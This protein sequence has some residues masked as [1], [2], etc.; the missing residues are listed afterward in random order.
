M[1]FS[2]F[3]GLFFLL[4][5]FF[6]LSSFLALTQGYTS[7]QR[8][9]L[10]LEVALGTMA[11]GITLFLLGNHIFALFGINL[12]SFRMGTG[13]LLMLSAINLVQGGS[14]A[15]LKGIDREAISI[16]PL[17]IPITVGPATVG[18]LL[19]L[20]SEQTAPAEAALT[21]GAFALAACAVGTLL[22]ISSWIERVLG[23]SG[24]TI[25]SKITGLILSALAAQMFMQGFT[26]F[27]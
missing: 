26:Q 14:T 16:V 20:S 17:A 1:F 10:A 7:A 4:T 21:L 9:R 3:I 25:L 27:L 13:I 11:V 12:H 23:R 8:R 19:V 6:V 15:P 5:P 22:F 18:Y 24:I 2:T